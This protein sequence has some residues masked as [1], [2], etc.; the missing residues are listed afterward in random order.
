[1][2]KMKNFSKWLRYRLTSK[3]IIF[4]RVRV[5]CKAK[6]VLMPTFEIAT[7]PQISLSEIKQ[8]RFDIIEQPNGTLKTDED[9]WL[10]NR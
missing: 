1:M 9:E 7:H 8:R 6:R 5:G 10:S 2:I 3:W 4:G